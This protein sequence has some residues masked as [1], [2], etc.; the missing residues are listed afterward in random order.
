MKKTF[1]L[2][3]LTVFV[4][5]L[6]A[7]LALGSGEDSGEVDRGSST[8]EAVGTPG[9]QDI[10][11]DSAPD[12]AANKYS[13]QQE[14]KV[15]GLKIVIGDIELRQSRVLVGLTI[16]NEAEDTL[17][18]YPDQG[19]AVMGSMQ[20]EANMFMT[21]GDASGDIRPGVEKSAVIHFLTP[22][23]RDVPDEDSITLYLGTVYNMESFSTEE[24]SE[25]F[26]LQ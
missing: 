21:D 6:F 14:Y 5:I 9:E 3:A 12:D 19:E 10:E 20:L 11:P 18:F 25:T 1:Y 8:D 17:T 24:F 13:I 7:L 23:D 22:E 15:N 4:L 2:S 16:K 26:L